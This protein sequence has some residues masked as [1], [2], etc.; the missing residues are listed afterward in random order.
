MTNG[1]RSA[2][3]IAFLGSGSVG[4]AQLPPEILVD[5]LLLRAERLIEGENLDAAV[6]AVAG[7]KLEQR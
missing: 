1:A 4:G 5:Q 3:L 6:E 2:L 7:R